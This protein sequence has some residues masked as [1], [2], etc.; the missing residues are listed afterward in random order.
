MIER[1]KVSL[2]TTYIV[3]PIEKESLGKIMSS[4]NPGIVH[5][6]YLLTNGLK[7]RQEFLDVY[8]NDKYNISATLSTNYAYAGEAKRQAEVITFMRDIVK[9][10]YSFILRF[11]ITRKSDMKEI[12][13]FK[14]ETTS[15]KEIVE[16]MDKLEQ[17]TRNLCKVDTY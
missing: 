8:D 10:R 16:L 9:R 4:N 5:R 12:F 17:K 11:T 15:K 6:I 2:D 14:H 3:K 13:N 7:K 1:I